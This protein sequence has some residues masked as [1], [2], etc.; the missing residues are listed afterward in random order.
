MA[1]PGRASDASGVA[2]RRTA[3]VLESV[4]GPAEH[5][6]GRWTYSEAGQR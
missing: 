5:V 4:A 3:A 1:H 2:L 6:V